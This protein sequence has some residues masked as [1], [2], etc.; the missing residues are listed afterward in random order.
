M[1]FTRQEPRTTGQ[2]LQVRKTEDGYIERTEVILQIYVGVSTVYS[3]SSPLW[4]PEPRTPYYIAY[5][6]KVVQTNTVAWV[7]TDS[8]LA[9]ASTF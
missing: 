4:P 2:I 9:E 1:W 8:I 3:P 5:P 7:D 6:V